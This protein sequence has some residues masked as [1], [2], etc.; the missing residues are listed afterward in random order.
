VVDSKAE[1]DAYKSLE[2]VLEDEIKVY[3]VLLDLVRREKEVLVS[4][5]IDELNENNR[6]KEIMILKIKSLERQREK[7]AREMALVVGTNPENPRLLDIAAK[8]L[9]PQS[10]KLRSIHSTLDL[11]VRRIKE[12]NESNEALIQA[13][14][15]AVNGA[16]GAIRETLQP[17]PTYAS[18][19][20]VK[21]NEVAGHFVS[22]EV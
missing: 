16:L 3:R 1:L 15:K 19:G 8:L 11:L 12:L 17:K 5:K 6:S 14:L 21:K 7:V 13:S 22:K 20:E 2:T 18:S 9:D 10:S 4:A